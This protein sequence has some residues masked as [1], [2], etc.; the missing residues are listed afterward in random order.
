MLRI[1]I[2]LLLLIP[3]LSHAGKADVLN[4]DI[5]RN[6][7][8]TYRFD[9]TLQ[10]SDEGWKHYA[11]RWEIM[12]PAGKIIATRTLL[13]PHV[14]EQPFTRGL[15]SVKIPVGIKQVVI[16]ANDLVHGV[17]GKKLTIT[18]PN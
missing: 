18:L 13:H 6:Q 9:V 15:S 14:H 17:G 1:L 12:S 7:D 2:T 16:R 11:N 8:G 3:S 5:T 4:A 10:H